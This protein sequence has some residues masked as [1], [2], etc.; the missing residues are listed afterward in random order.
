MDHSTFVGVRL[1]Q[2]RAADLDRQLERRRRVI[3][4][5]ITVAPTRPELTPL[6]TIGVWLRNRR[7]AV[8]I[9]TA[10]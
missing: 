3:D 5:G 2:H 9:G 8:R 6:H 10:Y 7:R 1:E 4:Q